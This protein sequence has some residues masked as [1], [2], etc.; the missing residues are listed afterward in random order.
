MKTP[1]YLLLLTLLALVLGGCTSSHVS[2][3]PTG[4]LIDIGMIDKTKY[5]G[6]FLFVQDSCVYLLMRRDEKQP[7]QVFR[8]PLSSVSSMRTSGY[9]NRE[10]QK[11]FLAFQLIPTVLFAIDIGTYA[12]HVDWG[13]FL[14]I[15]GGPSVITY[16]VLEGSTPRDPQSNAPFFDIDQFRKYARYPEGLD[17]QKLSQFLKL[18]GQTE[19]ERLP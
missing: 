18:Y 16:L 11:T 1:T 4:D 7:V 9:P 19:A 12:D 6:E 13:S 17:R 2:L 15:F 5:N 3:K 14:L 10:W 8:I